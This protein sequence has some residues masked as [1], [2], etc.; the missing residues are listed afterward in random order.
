MSIYDSNLWMKDVDLVLA[1]LP[2]LNELEGKKI[3]ITGAAGLI[4]SAVVDILIRYNEKAHSPIQIYAA[5]R[6]EQKMRDRFDRNYLKDFFHFVPYD[7]SVPDITFPF[8]ADY[9]IHG[10]ANSS[11]KKIVNEPVETMLGNFIG[12]RSL[13]DYAKERGTKRVLYI[14][15]SEV[16]G[17]KDRAESA[18]EDDYGF[19]DILV[20]RNSYSVGKQASETL[21]ISYVDEYD[22]DAVIVRPGHVYGPTANRMDDHVASVW[23][24][25]VA[26][27]KDIVMKSDGTQIRSYVY[28][29][30][31]ASAILKVLLCGEKGRAYNISNPESVI[32]IREMA[33]IMCVAGGVQLHIEVAS[34]EEKKGFNPMSNSSLDS[35]SLIA[36]GWNGCFDARSGIGHTVKILNSL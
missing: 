33:E 1:G 23:A 19:I 14:S 7:S 6:N 18:K 27:G 36:L 24:Y 21:C 10:A 22:M 5:G 32:S 8:D 31:C 20:P 2:E 16:Y 4:C 15:S 3:L 11:P 29:A 34:A 25:D 35:R 13:L 30:D 12:I 28:C 26:A 17:K 9:I